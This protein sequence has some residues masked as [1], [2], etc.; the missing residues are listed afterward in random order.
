MSVENPGRECDL[1]MKGGV[2]SGVVYP[3]AVLKLAEHYR[4]RNIG[5][6]S[7][8]AIAAAVTAAA[9]LGRSKGGF[10]V[11][12]AMPAYVAN[13][14]TS[15]FQ[16]EPRFRRLFKM[17]LKLQSGKGGFWRTARIL[18][19]NILFGGLIGSVKALP[20]RRFGLCPGVTQSG[21]SQ[22]GLIDWLSEQ[23]ERAAGR[24]TQDGNLPE[25]P[26][27]FSDLEGA[28][29]KPI[30]LQMVTTNLSMGRPYTLPELDMTYY[31][32]RQE[33]AE[34]FPKNVVGYLVE[35]GE[36]LQRQRR[37]DNPNAPVDENHLPLPVGGAMPVIVAVR[38]SLSFPFLFQAI[39]LYKQF[40][41]DPNTPIGQLDRVLFSDGGISSNF[42]VHFFDALLPSR[43]T[44]GISLDPYDERLRKERIHLPVHARS[45]QWMAI[46]SVTGL[47]AFASSILGAAREWQDNLQGLLPGYRE[48]IVHIALT[49]DEG[50]LNLE[51]PSD[52]IE[53]LL[54]YGEQ[55][56]E[57]LTRPID[58]GGF[59]FDDHQWRRFLTL[60]GRLEDLMGEI[61]E[62]WPKMKGDLRQYAKK[63]KSYDA[64]QVHK[65][66]ALKRM[67]ELEA[68]AAAWARAPISGTKLPSPKPEPDLS[69]R[70]TY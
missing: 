32:D 68:L 55:G 28:Q 40:Y 10:T 36:E 31:F 44:F 30:R 1:V 39:P 37:A 19:R 15:L 61:H 14:L 63:P 66:A 45:G 67:D 70:A 49:E 4:F 33:F 64:P 5:G 41:P 48:R 29:P 56:G 18:A 47:G 3:K 16:P 8:G 2:T 13:N 34:L 65:Q 12:E 22:P 58:A 60:Y 11:V 69:I 26:L 42:P 6:T 35:K 62:C 57:A 25:R 38:M 7:A 23:M 21:Q 54:A 59:D 46:R 17:L 20:D 43:P 24:L 53:A 51:M 9:E 27:L 50:G 52:T